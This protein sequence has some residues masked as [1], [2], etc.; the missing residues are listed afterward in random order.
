MDRRVIASGTPPSV[1][2]A[3]RALEMSMTG[4]GAGTDGNVVTVSSDWNAAPWVLAYSI[5]TMRSAADFSTKPSRRMPRGM[6]PS[7]VGDPISWPADSFPAIAAILLNVASMP[8]TLSPESTMYRVLRYRSTPGFS[9]AMP[10]TAGMP[11]SAPT[12]T[13]NAPATAP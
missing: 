6:Y 3:T 1:T 2:M 11:I 10:V 5:S 9:N 12:S 4:G 8:E 7:S 13:H